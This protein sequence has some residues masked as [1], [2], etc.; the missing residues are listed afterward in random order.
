MALNLISSV[1]LQMSLICSFCISIC[2]I[3]TTG[4]WSVEEEEA[5]GIEGEGKREEEEE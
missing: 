3:L 4:H 1:D 2:L 5:G